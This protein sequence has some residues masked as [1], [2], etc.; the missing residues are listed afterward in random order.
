MKKMKN[1][2]IMSIALMAVFVLSIN[3]QVATVSGQNQFIETNFELWYYTQAGSRMTESY[4]L[5]IKQALAPLG[6]EVKIIAKPWGQFVGDLLH[7]TTGHPFDLTHIRFTGG[8]PTPGFMWSYHSTRTSFGQ[9]M[10]QLHYPEFQE[11]QAEDAGVT[12]EEVDT[13]LEDIEFELNL[14]VRLD[15]VTEFN[16]L[17]MTKLLY[18]MPVIA[19]T[20]LVAMWKGYGGENNELW[21]PEEGM[22]GSRALGATWTS[23]TPA[24]RVSNSTHIRDSTVTPGVDGMFDPNQ[25]FDSAT[26][27]ITRYMTQSMLDFDASF[28]AHP[29]IAWNFM[30]NETFGDT[31]DHDNNAT[32]A[33]VETYELTWFLGD[34]VMWAPTVDVNGDAVASEAVDAQ[35]FVLAYDMFKHPDTVLNGKEMFDPIVDYYASTTVFTD[36]TFTVKINANEV[37]PDDY[38]TFGAMDPVPFHLLG[39]SL[40]NGTHS[41]TVANPAIAGFNP[42]ETE[43]WELW[44]HMDGHT[45]PGPF[46][47]VEYKKGEFY[48]YAARDDFS[49]PNEDD[50][51]TYYDATA[52]AAIE[53]EFGFDFEVF[54]PHENTVNPDVFYWG[55]GAA[56]A[57]PTTQG[58]T[59]FEWVVIDDV[60]ARLLAFES[61]N[62]DVFGST[63]LGAQTVENHQNNPNL[64][65]K[66]S[67]PTRGP[68]LIVFNLLNPDLKKINVRLAIAHAIDKDELVKIHDG[69]A[70]PHHSVVWPKLT[71]WVVPH[72]I[73]YDYNVSRDLMR[74][75]GYKALETPEF[76]NENPAAPINEVFG[77]LGSEYLFFMSA[78]ALVAVVGLRRRRN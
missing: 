68:E 64:V 7:Y 25:S 4:A 50:V 10:Y 41:D 55:Y 9:S 14:A 2:K 6:I 74:S 48:S 17:Y 34:Q 58:I 57:K 46:D 77:L 21:S 22:M 45:L 30:F 42:Q 29:G 56:G 43:E 33:E 28:G 11:W 69:F 40:T 27:D 31:Y 73:A 8:G 44:A 19:Q 13:L 1:I 61:G 35:D 20:Y 62:L 23:F 76:V 60:N 67:I 36:D 5:Y 54:A 47:V 72:E 12:T 18:D 52:L 38:F 78:V 39:G 32:T 49:Y 70:K 16:E 75:E 65:V 53:A 59:T 37:T 63:G 51:A 3:G 26:T 24:D 15:L 66:E 71:N